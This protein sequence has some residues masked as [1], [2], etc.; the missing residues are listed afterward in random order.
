V[1]HVLLV[2]RRLFGL[3]LGPALEQSRYDFQVHVDKH[4]R[5]EIKRAAG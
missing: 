3:L 1:K 5:Y 4:Q 2:N